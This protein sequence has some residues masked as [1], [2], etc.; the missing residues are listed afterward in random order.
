METGQA[1]RAGVS[2]IEIKMN[3]LMARHLQEALTK[4]PWLQFAHN[5]AL[6][7]LPSEELQDR[8]PDSTQTSF[9]TYCVII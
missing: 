4:P 8:D 5:G 6:P 9:Q 3:Q 1:L 7:L 2:S